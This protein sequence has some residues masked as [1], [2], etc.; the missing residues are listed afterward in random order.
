MKL[1]I[2][3]LQASFVFGFCLLVLAVPSGAVTE[4]IAGV[5]YK[6]F[7]YKEELRAP[8]KSTEKAEFFAP[9]VQVRLPIPSLAQS[10]VQL[11]GEMSGNV[12]SHFDG[13][14]QSG[15][16][17]TDTN[18]L[19][20]ADFDALFY[21]NFAPEFFLQ[22]GFGY[23]YWNRFLSGGA[24]YREIYTWYY[25]PIGILYQHQVSNSFS[26][27]VDLTYRMM[28]QGQIKVIFSETVTNGDDTDLT[29]GDRPGYRLQIPLRYAFEGTDFGVLLAPWYEFSEIGASD[30]KHN[31][32]PTTNGALGFIQEPASK[33]IQFGLQIGMVAWF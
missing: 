1:M 5:N 2:S 13:T 14:T 16:P 20:F 27:G 25:I 12:N 23:H 9:F 7:D 19:S 29:L 8:L 24:G 6:S 31:S 33:T 11:S 3:K 4:L 32:T 21:W 15:V 22:A 18:T 30:F 26:V 10:F 28:F 17:V